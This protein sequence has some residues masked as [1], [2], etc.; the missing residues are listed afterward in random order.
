MLFISDVETLPGPMS[1]AALMHG[2][3][4]LPIIQIK[5]PLNGEERASFPLSI[6]SPLFDCVKLLVICYIF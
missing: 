2:L 1:W 5:E 4:Y 3:L 6:C